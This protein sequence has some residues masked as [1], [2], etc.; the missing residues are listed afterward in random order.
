[1]KRKKKSSS[2]LK[3]LYD[4]VDRPSVTGQ[5]RKQK[6]KRKSRY[7]FLICVERITKLIL[8]LVARPELQKKTKMYLFVSTLS[9]RSLYFLL[10]VSFVV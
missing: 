7:F 8:L 4:S 2:T 9:T 6:E 1:M 5:G 10:H 3:P